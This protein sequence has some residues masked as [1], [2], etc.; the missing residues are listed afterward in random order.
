MS[1]TLST[2]NIVALAAD[3]EPTT[4]GWLAL[5]DAAGGHFPE[6]AP[7]CRVD[8]TGSLRF[9]PPE[10][11]LG[12]W[13]ACRDGIVIGALR[14]A[15][16]D[17]AE[18]AR[19]DQLLVHP[20]ARRQ[21]IGRMLHEHALRQAAEHGAATLTAMIVEALPDGPH[22]DLAPAAFAA[23]MGA[24]R[25]PEPAGLHQWLDL[26]TTDP[27]AS[28]VP[29]MPDGYRLVTWGTITPDEYAIAVSTLERSLGTGQWDSE[30]DTGNT[31]DTS[32][33]R[34]FE[35]M[36]VGRGRRAYHTGVIYEASDRLVGY[37]SISKTTG[38]PEYALQGMTVVHDAHRGHGLGLILKL[39]NLE[40]ALRHEPGLRKLETANDETNTAMVAVNAAM[41]Y[42]PDVRWV[43]W[44]RP[45]PQRG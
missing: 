4:E 14:L 18:V 29:A 34:R 1:R 39:A 40:Y 41:G 27:L 44:S 32:Y 6:S 5:L 7:P 31:V 30:E 28:G 10:V 15:F 19:V 3:D 13:V 43:R 17:G 16:P 23:A 25:S 9:A 24:T 33:A 42:R 26:D 2:V 12:D 8:L 22:R 38:N 35:T 45:V 20:D 11:T 21:G 36:R 37:T